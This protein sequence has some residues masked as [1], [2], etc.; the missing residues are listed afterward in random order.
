MGWMCFC[1]WYV[2]VLCIWFYLARFKTYW[3]FTWKW[4]SLLITGEVGQG[5]F[6]TVVCDNNH[7]GRFVVIYFDHPGTLTVCEF[8]VYSGMFSWDLTPL[9]VFTDIKCSQ[10]SRLKLLPVN[11]MMLIMMQFLQYTNLC[12]QDFNRLQFFYAT[13]D[14]LFDSPFP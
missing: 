1:F 8:E 12:S 2:T 4:F 13:L 11:F 6:R 7:I 3:E 14:Y 5:E 9:C 10:N